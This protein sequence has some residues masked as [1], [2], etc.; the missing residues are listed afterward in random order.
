MSAV[1]DKPKNVVADSRK[2]GTE[3]PS[4]DAIPDEI[5]AAWGSA[6]AAGETPAETTV[7]LLRSVRWQLSLLAIL[8]VLGVL[9]FAKAVFV[10]VALSVVLSLLL[11]PAVRWMSRRHIP[12]TLAAIL[13]L[14]AV[15][16]VITAGILPLLSPARE[17]LDKLPENLEKA[18]AKLEVLRDNLGQLGKVRT[19]IAELAAGAGGEE[20]RPAF[21]VTVKEPELTSSA[22]MLSTTGNLVGMWLVVIVLTFF[23]LIEGDSLLNSV[24]TLMPTFRQKRRIVEFVK[25]VEGNVSSYLVTITLINAGLG[26]AIGTVL[27]LMGVP[28]APVWGLMTAVFNYVPFIGQGVAGIIIGFVALLSFDS[29]GYALLVPVVFYAIAAVEGNIITPALLGRRMSLNPILVLLFLIWWGWM[30]GIS[31]AALAVPILAVVKISC[32]HFELISTTA[33]AS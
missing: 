21:P 4:P 5:A 12:P 23:L 31:G 18:N 19:Q 8:A 17:W 11:R 20:E 29:F 25:A 9:Y 10:P 33:P 1:L 3:S 15:G 24:L 26:I 13:C 6:V 22:V 2:S 27:W 16:I 28:N 14:C 32:D 7:A 30:W